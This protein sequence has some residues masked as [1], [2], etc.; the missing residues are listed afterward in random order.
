MD[1]STDDDENESDQSIDN[2]STYS[3]IS[4]L[5]TGKKKGGESD[6]DMLQKTKAGSTPIYGKY[7]TIPSATLYEHTSIDSI[8][9]ASNI[10]NIPSTPDTPM[11]YQWD[12]E[13]TEQSTS[14]GTTSRMSYVDHIIY[15]DLTQIMSLG[16]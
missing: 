6:E 7:S 5:H 15:M 8:I 3:D 2:G 1:E 4:S 9:G 13:R 11:H 14:I 16:S 10:T 12:P